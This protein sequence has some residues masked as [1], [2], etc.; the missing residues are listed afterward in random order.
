MM[1]ISNTCGVTLLSTTGGATCG[2]AWRLQVTLVASLTLVACNTCGM[3][4]ESNTR[5]VASSSTT[6][7]VAWR[8]QVVLMAW[9]L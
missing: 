9:R 2:V 5:G 7:G 1:T 4:S 6:D 8:V 3:T